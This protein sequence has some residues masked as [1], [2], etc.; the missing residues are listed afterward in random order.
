[1]VTRRGVEPTD[2]AVKN[3]P[4]K[5][6]RMKRISSGGR[7]LRKFSQRFKGRYYRI[8]NYYPL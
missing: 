7:E 6:R 2:F 8:T 3:G 5:S 4:Y 1:M